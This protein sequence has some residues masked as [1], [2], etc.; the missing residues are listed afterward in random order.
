MGPGNHATGDPLLQLGIAPADDALAEGDSLDAPLQCDTF[1][2]RS[3]VAESELPRFR[4]VQRA[5]AGQECHD[6][7]SAALD[8]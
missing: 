6:R 5:D 3:D 4:H 1:A 2:L 7:S 8:A